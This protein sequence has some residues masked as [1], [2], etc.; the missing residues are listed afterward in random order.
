M[1]IKIFFLSIIMLKNTQG[2]SLCIIS[3]AQCLAH[4]RH[5]INPELI[6]EVDIIVL[7][8]DDKETEVMITLVYG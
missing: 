3:P 6:N 7:L 8:G 2:Q 1:I 4:S 5:L